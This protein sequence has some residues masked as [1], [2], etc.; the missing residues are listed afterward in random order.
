MHLHDKNLVVMLDKEI[1]HLNFRDFM[2]LEGKD[3]MVEITDELGIAR[4]EIKL[5]KKKMSRT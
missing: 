3:H 2:E 4:E 1:F 5:M